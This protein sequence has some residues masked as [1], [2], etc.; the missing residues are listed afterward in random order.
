MEEIILEKVRELAMPILS[1][2]GTELVDLTYRRESG[3]MVL[4]F[5]VDKA[6]WIT[7][8]ECGRLSRRIEA[9]LDEA[10][11]IEERYILEVQSPGLDR[12]LEKTSDFERAIGKE[13]KV[14]TYGPIA[15]RREHAGRLKWV[16]EEKI[17]IETPEGGEVEIPR[18]IIAKAKLDV[19]F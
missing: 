11:V 7:I 10:N 16:G 5:T 4:R 2:T 9:L 18:N 6:G 19:K 13:I 12:K 17:T 15:D 8:D 1:E 14:N 3:G